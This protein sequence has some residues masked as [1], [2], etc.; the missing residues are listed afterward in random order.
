M[1][2]ALLSSSGLLG[3]S[4]RTDEHSWYDVRC[5]L[6]WGHYRGNYCNANRNVYVWGSDAEYDKGAVAALLE[7][8]M[9]Q[10]AELGKT[11]LRHQ[12]ISE[13]LCSHI[14]PPLI[15]IVRVYDNSAAETPVVE[16]GG[17]VMGY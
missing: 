7:T 13:A 6:E 2:R 9:R 15:A 12:A 5:G 1:G 17:M 16:T 14:L 10:R 11:L 8:R 4:K 3:F